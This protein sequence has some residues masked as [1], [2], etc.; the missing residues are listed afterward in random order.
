MAHPS[1]TAYDGVLQCRPPHAQSTRLGP[2]PWLA[3]IR[4][5]CPGCFDTGMRN[6]Y[7]AKSRY[8]RGDERPTDPVFLF[9]MPCTCQ[10]GVL[11]RVRAGL[12]ALDLDA[13]T[14]PVR[15]APVDVAAERIAAAAAA[16]APAPIT[17]LA[18]PAEYEPRPVA[19]AV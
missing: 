13:R 4:R 15:V 18:L 8:R 3:Q 12:R 16:V 10:A 19:V 6:V 14:T 2:V 7:G 11:V 1:Q 5:R 17:P 9:T